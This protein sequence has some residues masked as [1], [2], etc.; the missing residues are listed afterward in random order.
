MSFLAWI[1]RSR[2]CCWADVVPA[3]SPLGEGSGYVW[4]SLPLIAGALA[5]A[6]RAWRGKAQGWLVAAGI[7][8]LLIGL[9]A[10]GEWLLRQRVLR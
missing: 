2:A 9:L 3:K 10:G 1:S 7:A 4:L 8:Y 6:V 5:N